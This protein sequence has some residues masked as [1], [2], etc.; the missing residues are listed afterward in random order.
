M[1]GATLLATWPQV[2][3]SANGAQT[4]M[5][6]T[7]M[8]ANFIATEFAMSDDRFFSYYYVEQ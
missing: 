2:M 7:T 5:H 3:A 1:Q 8:Q 4:T 6:I